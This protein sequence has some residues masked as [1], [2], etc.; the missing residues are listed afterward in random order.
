MAQAQLANKY[1]WKSIPDSE[2]VA[3]NG[4]D[5]VLSYPKRQMSMISGVGSIL[6][7]NDS[8]QLNSLIN[9]MQGIYS[10]AVV[11]NYSLTL[12]Q[13]NT[14]PHSDAN[15]WWHDDPDLDNL[16]AESGD[17]DLLAYI[18]KQWRQETGV[19]ML[20]LY[21]QYV[22][23]MNKGELGMLFSG[24]GYGRAWL[25]KRVWLFSR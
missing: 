9:E 1:D 13:C 14:H 2:D 11:C 23:L 21:Q 22:V 10:T 7:K 8:T 19:T 25:K 18:W 6:N 24:R 17:Y 3:Y 4:S 15:V 12:D 20:P 5:K 16:F